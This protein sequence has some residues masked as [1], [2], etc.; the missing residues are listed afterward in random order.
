MQHL[1]LISEEEASPEK[2]PKKYYAEIK[3]PM[4]D[5]MKRNIALAMEKFEQ[6]AELGNVRSM[7]SVVTWAEKCGNP[8]LLDH[9][10][11]TW[12]VAA[13]TAETP[14]PNSQID[15]AKILENDGKLREAQ[16][17]LRN[18]SEVGLEKAQLK[19]KDFKERHPELED[20]KSSV[21]NLEDKRSFIK[22]LGLEKEEQA[23]S[24]VERI[25]SD[26]TKGKSLGGSNEL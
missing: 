26:P 1:G 15:Y 5:N 7:G 12:T 3:T 8:E 19:L 22:K 10:N 23:K 20:K 13:A 11:R 16:T 21:G 14:N 9:L 17:M 25:R 18:A 2:D 4:P 6:S 24:F